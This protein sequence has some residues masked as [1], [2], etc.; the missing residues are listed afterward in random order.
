MF[1]RKGVSTSGLGLRV[2]GHVVCNLTEDREVIIAR[3]GMV[4]CVVWLVVLGGRLGTV[5]GHAWS[6][7]AL[8]QP[9]LAHEH[10]INLALLGS[11]C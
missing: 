8:A 3:R 2:V 1:L 4:L 7:R 5:R 11:E 10:L 9:L 6:S